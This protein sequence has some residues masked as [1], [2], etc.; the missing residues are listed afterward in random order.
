MRGAAGIATAAVLLGACAHPPAAPVVEHVGPMREVMREGRTEPRASLAAHTVAGTYGV[1]ALAALDGE[2]L[3]DDG[4][5]WI[6]RGGVD[7]VRAGADAQATLLTTARVPA[8]RDVALPAIADGAALE[9]ALAAAVPD[10]A[11]RGDAVPFVLEGRG[12]VALHVVR[13]GCPHGAATPEQEPARLHA[14]DV[15]LRC[16]GFFVRGQGGVMTHHGTALHVHAFV[17]DGARTVMGHVDELALAAGAML[18]VP[19]ASR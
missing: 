13:G 5:A 17:R 18:R 2:V 14:D 3:I 1:G 9:A 12:R 6:A 4:T 15:A 19:A 10:A 11:A 8:W 16:V 7:A